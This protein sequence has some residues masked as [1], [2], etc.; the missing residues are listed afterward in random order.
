MALR[1]TVISRRMVLR[2]VLAG[3]V[4]V[5]VP[6]P[7]LFGM[8]NDNGTAY[9]ADGAPLPVRF[10]VW[11][12]G[13]GIIPERWVPARTGQGNSWALSEQLAPL[14]GIK[15]W[16]SVVSGCSVKVPDSAPHASMPA[17]A[18]SGANVGANGFQMASIDQQ[19]A[20]VI[21]TGTVFPTGLHVG[22]SNT[23]GGTALGSLISSAGPSAPNPPD[24]SPANLF[25]KLMQ[26]AM[27]G[28]GTTPLPPDPELLRRGLILD[29]VAEDAKLLRGRLGMEDQLRLDQHM[30]GVKQLQLQI[31]RA[32]GP[33]VARTLADPDKVYVGRGND[34]TI[35][36]ARGQA[37]SDLLVFALSTDLTRVFT[38]MFTCAACHGNY[39][40]C[41]LDP[42]TFHEDYG[43]RL[44][45]KG[46]TYATAGFNTG[47]RFAMSN[48]SDT[49]TRMKDTPDGTGNLLD[50][51]CIYTTSCTSESQTHSNLDYPLL[52]AGKA[53]G[54]LKGDMHVRLIG[55]NTSKL[56]FTLLTMMGSTAT[57]F[58]QAEGQVTARIPELL[59]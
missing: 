55:E 56:P 26:F 48:L 5:A 10:G 4:S 1:R 15:P 19:I 25:K 53:G 37:F 39:S 14:Q 33:K 38:Y 32:Q 57:T 9:A 40:D 50:N 18:L 11:F 24:F 59:A 42:A 47:V 44:S 36:R 22:V 46:Q 52:V 28:P 21:G 58:G 27:T 8:L 16:L 20:K 2:G 41:G 49:L 7:R 43:H 54:K 35:T 34:G 17:A 13:N 6:L 51:S 3:G 30:E 31:T 12:F 45:P 29:A 23:S